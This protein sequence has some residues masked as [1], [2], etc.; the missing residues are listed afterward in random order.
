MTNATEDVL[1]LP[2]GFNSVKTALSMSRGPLISVI[3]V[4]KDCRAP[5][6]TF[7][8]GMIVRLHGSCQ[9]THCLK[10][11]FKCTIRVYD[12]STAEGEDIELNIFRRESDMPVVGCGDVVVMTDVKVGTY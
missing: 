6:S 7:G 8:S 2:K 9:L 1:P 10:L 4:V 3:G 11:D 12:T 5:T